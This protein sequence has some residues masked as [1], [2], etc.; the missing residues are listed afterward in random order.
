MN[1]KGITPFNNHEGT[2]DIMNFSSPNERAVALAEYTIKNKCTVRESAAHF[3]V[4]KST[5]H[6][7][8]TTT[9]PKISKALYI[10]VKEILE[11]NKADR[12]IRGGEATRKKYE[13]R[14]KE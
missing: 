6:K 9:L 1:F 5:V 3:G 7:D 10:A 13:E 14:R 12:H 8:L 11:L 2:T 4:S